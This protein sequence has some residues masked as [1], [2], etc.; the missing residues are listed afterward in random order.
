M[1][2]YFFW[3]AIYV[4]VILFF[5]I[6]YV[7]HKNVD[8]YLINNRSTKTL[9][10]V[11]TTLAT[12]VGGG[13][14][15]GLIAMGYTSGLAA[16]AIGI[17]YVLGFFIL[18]FFAG[19][20]RTYGAEHNIYSFAEYLNRRYL[21]NHKNSAFPK[22][23][24]G[25]ISGINILIF[26]FL[27]AA[28]FVGMA[29][30]LHYAFDVGYVTAAGISFLL[31]ITYTALA[32]LSGVIITDSIQFIVI[33]F[34]IIAIFIPGILADTNN[35]TSLKTLDPAMLNGTSEG[36]I[37]LLGLPLLLA[38][39][40]LTRMDIWQRTLSAKSAK[41]AKRT[42]WISGLS[43]LPFY[44]IFP[45]VGMA[46]RVDYGVGIDP[47]HATFE[48][49]A[50]HTAP[51]LLGFATIGLLSALMSSADS[52]LNIVAMTAVRDFS[53]YKVGFQ[54]KADSFKRIRI[55]VVVFGAIALVMALFFADIVNLFV[56]GITMNILFTPI[57]I[58][59]LLRKD[60]YRYKRAAFASI[61]S[62]TIVILAIF[63]VGFSTGNDG[64][65]KIAFVPATLIATIALFIGLY[66]QKQ[67]VKN[68]IPNQN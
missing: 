61:L 57:T 44:I 12:F 25:M 14:C 16:V 8:A 17:A 27:T 9:P 41:T 53:S 28:Q 47:N 34:M 39:S 60:V 20:I 43:M 23:F 32:G 1:N 15:M 42:A 59:A 7:K 35:F 52:F 49:L 21:K 45:L 67:K 68:Q 19:K 26:F 33:V 40:V 54:S 55:A 11:F 10:L 48:F 37:F 36:L 38:P 50:K 18:Y 5:T 6:K 46:L 31:V 4:V 24:S 29:S 64:L 51:V 66:R 58:L 62:G 63:T 2:W 13:V 3:I 22:F 65:L 56:A 30:L